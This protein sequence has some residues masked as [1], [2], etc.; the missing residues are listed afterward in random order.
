[1]SP[2]SGEGYPSQDP[3]GKYITHPERKKIMRKIFLPLFCI[4]LMA[5]IS[6]APVRAADIKLGV[7]DTQRIMTESKAAIA[8]HALFAKEVEEKRSAYLAKQKEAQA[9]QEELNSKG[10]TMSVSVLAEKQ[11]KL[12]QEIK[13]LNRMKSDI[14]QDL[15]IRDNELSQELLTEIYDVISEYSEKEGFTLILEKAGVVT[16]DNAIDITDKII[17]LY[18]STQ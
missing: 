13:E 9:L 14:E 16:F 11:E 1:M 18:N 12:S 6:I 5:S 10:S 3:W 15:K 7:I 2:G 17:Q 8:A 4:C